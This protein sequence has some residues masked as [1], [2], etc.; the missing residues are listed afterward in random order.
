M[1]NNMTLSQLTQMHKLQ[2]LRTRINILILLVS[3][4]TIHS[5]I[6]TS[7]TCKGIRNQDGGAPSTEKYHGIEITELNPI[8]NLDSTQDK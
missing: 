7:L 2:M 1:M 4:F 6:W 3:L 8:R 5:M